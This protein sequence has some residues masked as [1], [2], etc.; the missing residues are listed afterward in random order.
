M[1]CLTRLAFILPAVVVCASSRADTAD[2]TIP[3]L[4]VCQ[5]LRN[6]GQYSGQTVIVVGRSVGTDEG[7]WLDEECGSKI[8]IQGRS[9]EAAISTAYSAN[10]FAP[11]PRKPKGFKWNKRLLRQALKEV[12]ETTHLERG[13]RWYGVYGRLEAEPTRTINLNNG[14]TATTAGYTHLSAAPAQI[15]A[16]SDGYLR[17]E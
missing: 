14:R 11:P 7:S 16:A 1:R 12:K 3:V 13:A 10:D 2:Q 8:V 5:V 9:Y 4:T 17:L 6:P 15:I